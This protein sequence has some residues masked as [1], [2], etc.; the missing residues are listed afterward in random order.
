[1]PGSASALLVAWR[2][3]VGKPGKLRSFR[4]R[5]GVGAFI[6]AGSEVHPGRYSVP[7]SMSPS[8]F[9]TAWTGWTGTGVPGW[10]REGPRPRGLRLDGKWRRFAAA[11]GSGTDR[12]R[13][14]RASPGLERSTRG[15][16]I[17]PHDRGPWAPRKGRGRSSLRSVMGQVPRGRPPGAPSAR[18]RMHAGDLWCVLYNAP[19]ALGLERGS[20]SKAMAAWLAPPATVRRHPGRSLTHVTTP[21]SRAVLALS[22]WND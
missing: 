5:S 11:R 10:R 9:F 2:A 21:R 19:S 12:T 1:M 22:G 18:I 8:D 17:R 7:S 14:S 16:G 6:L 20:R 15:R 4:L 13:G 3:T